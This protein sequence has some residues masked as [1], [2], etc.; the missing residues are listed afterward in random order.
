[1]VGAYLGPCSSPRPADGHPGRDGRAQ[2]GPGGGGAGLGGAQA[3]PAGDGTVGEGKEGGDARGLLFGYAS[4][5]HFHSYLQVGWFLLVV[6][7]L[8]FRT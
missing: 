5:G 3:G 4:M 6:V 8:V 1:M 2:D 7:L